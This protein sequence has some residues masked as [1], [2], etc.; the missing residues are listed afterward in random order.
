MV[1]SPLCNF[2]A[3]ITFTVSFPQ[4]LEALLHM[5]PAKKGFTLSVTLAV[6]HSVS[7][8]VYLGDTELT[9]LV[10]WGLERERERETA[11]RTGAEWKLSKQLF[12]VWGKM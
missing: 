7:L 6:S 9:T 3:N 4:D 10:L 2:K 1:K 11:A 5:H 8:G 12:K